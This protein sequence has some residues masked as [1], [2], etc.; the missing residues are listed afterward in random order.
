MKAWDKNLDFKELIHAD[1]DINSVLN[2]KEI[3]D[4]FSLEPYLEKIDYI[5]ERVFANES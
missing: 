2:P 3:E 1:K 4:C 5:Y